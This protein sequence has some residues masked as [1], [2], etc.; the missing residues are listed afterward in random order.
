MSNKIKKQIRRRSR[1]RSKLTT[2][3]RLR[4]SVN[5]SNKFMY[6]QLIDDVNNKTIVGISEKDLNDKKGTKSERAKNLGLAMASKAKAKKAT[7]IVFDRGSYA[8]HGRVKNFAEGLREGG[9]NF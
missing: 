4:L 6:A 2:K 8:Y 1:V 7:K 3:D 5:R 9:I